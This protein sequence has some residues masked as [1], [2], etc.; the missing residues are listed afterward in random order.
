MNQ[1][2]SFLPNPVS[3][4]DITDKTTKER[5]LG[6]VFFEVRPIQDL[7]LKANFGIDRNYQKRKQYMPTTTL[8]GARENGSGYIAQADNSDY[9][10]ELTANYTK[11]FGDHNLKCIGWS[12]LPVV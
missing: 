5:L 10:M 3:L 1:D 6:T 11:Q 4:L 7:L 9:L 12:F 8:Y 2:A